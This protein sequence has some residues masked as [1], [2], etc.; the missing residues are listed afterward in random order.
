[1]YL[2]YV[3]LLK[4][5]MDLVSLKRGWMFTAANLTN[6]LYSLHNKVMFFFLLYLTFL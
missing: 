6:N 2:K 5:K 1:M 4:K 3:S